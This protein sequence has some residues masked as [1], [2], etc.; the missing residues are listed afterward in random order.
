MGGAWGRWS[1]RKGK[2]RR[3]RWWWEGGGK[4]RGRMQRRRP[5]GH[6]ERKEYEEQERGGR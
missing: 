6:L 1:G 5:L 4:E 3:R 2:R